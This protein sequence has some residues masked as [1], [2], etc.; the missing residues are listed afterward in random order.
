MSVWGGDVNKCD[1]DGTSPIWNADQNGH[2][3]CLQLLLA[4]RADP[5]SSWKGTSALDTARKR[6][7]AECVRLLEAALV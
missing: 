3:E 7:H 5:R 2:A 6:N 4:S 1:N